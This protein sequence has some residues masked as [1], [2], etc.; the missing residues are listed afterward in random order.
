MSGSRYDV[1]FTGEIR[2]NLDPAEVTDNFARLFKISAEK[3]NQYLNAGRVVL[4]SGV[5]AQTAEKYRAALAEVGLV[6]SLEA[7]E[8]DSKK[9]APEPATAAPAAAASSA[10]TEA[11]GPVWGRKVAGP[12]AGSAMTPAPAPEDEEKRRDSLERSRA[13]EYHLQIGEVLAEAWQKVSGNKMT[14]FLSCL[15]Y[16]AIALGVSLGAGLIQGILIILG[17]E[18]GKV[19]GAILAQVLQITVTLPAGVGLFMLGVRL[20]VDAP[21]GADTILNYYKQIRPLVLTTL[22]MYAM[23]LLG[24]LLFIIP[25]IYLSV[26]YLLALPLVVDKRLSPWQA[27]ETSRKAIT[28][29]WF[30][31]FGLFMLLGLLYLAGCIPLLIGLIWVIPL[32]L[33]AMG[34]LYRNIFG[35]SSV[36]PAS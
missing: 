23:V 34:I 3:A 22:L 2:D 5:E 33:I 20:A 13:G 28:H 27:L 26:A 6:V 36:S 25:G 4:K 32:G 15:L 29:R 18:N 11:V 9:P 30:T 19:I 14:V 1:V 24:F 31:V 21:A 8:A 7:Q 12:A 17:G 10:T 35:V 16:L